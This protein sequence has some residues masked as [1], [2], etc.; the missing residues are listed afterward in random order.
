MDSTTHFNHPTAKRHLLSEDVIKLQ[1][2]QQRK[3]AVAHH[4]SGSEGEVVILVTGTVLQ[5]YVV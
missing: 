1:D 3:L 4:V 2:F 5:I